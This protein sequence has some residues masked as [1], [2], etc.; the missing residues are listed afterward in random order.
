[1]FWTQPVGS[2]RR[3]RFAAPLALA[4]GILLLAAN[5]IGHQRAAT[6]IA[7][8]E[9][10]LANRDPIDRLLRTVL[11]AESGQRGYLITGRSEYL[12]PYR[13]ASADVES[14]L[15]TL[16]ERYSGEPHRL[17]EVRELSEL[18][19]QKMAELKTTMALFDE[20]KEE[21][22]RNLML[23]DIGREKM[24]AITTLARSMVQRE[25]ERVATIGRV[26]DTTLLVAR[27]G[28]AAMILVSLAALLAFMQ[29]A[30]RL[31]I[32]RAAR[33]AEVK[34]ERDRL[35]VEV[36]RRT[37]E[38]TEIARHLQSAREDERSRLARELHDELGG[39]LTAAKLDVARIRNRIAGTNPEVGERISHLVKSLDA[40]IALKRRI[41]ED[42]RPSSLSNLGLKAALDILCREFA[43]GSE[44]ELISDIDEVALDEA[45]QLTVYRLVQEALTNVAKYAKARRVS[46]ELHP[47]EGCAVVTV[48]DDGVGFDTSV[49]Q[50]AVHGLAG[51]RFRV[52]SAA[53]KL[54]VQ[55]TP[56]AGTMIVA[57]LP[58]AA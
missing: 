24:Q 2:L 5:E 9:Q 17:A 31:D 50:R 35:E 43:D 57:S 7:E 54:T 22:W 33:S 13:R 52:H 20:K 39:L 28:L 11:E 48:R 38:I 58:L 53:G 6:V 40:G 29:Q 12:E 16:A 1:M 41:I 42:L 27:L 34:A 25:N 44:I 49:R 21:A 36:E 55:S 8:R 3:S 23:T 37:L 51:M 32:E 45:G 10:M 18:V 30:R 15:S 47:D 19:R 56:G 26:L 46:V 14:V 4:V